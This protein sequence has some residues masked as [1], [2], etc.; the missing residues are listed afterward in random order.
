MSAQQGNIFLTTE[1]LAFSLPLIAVCTTYAYFKYVP[2]EYGLPILGGL[3]V[4]YMISQKL[5]ARKAEKLQNLDESMVKD[6]VGEDD[7]AAKKK[8]TKAQKAEQKKKQQLAQRLK[9]EKKAGN[10]AA[11]DDDDDDDDDALRK[12]A[13]GGK[14]KT[15]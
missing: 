3:F 6:L 1:N 7:Q 11:Q 9:A 8:L 15:K 12:F 14:A 13:K 5:Q 2:L 4:I 10:N